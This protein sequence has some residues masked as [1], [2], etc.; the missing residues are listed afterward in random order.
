MG[1]THEVQPP[2]LPA[3]LP[4]AHSPAHT[5]RP[6]GDQRHGPHTFAQSPLFV[7]AVKLPTHLSFT[8]RNI[9]PPIGVGG[10]GGGTSAMSAPASHTRYGFSSPQATEQVR[11]RFVP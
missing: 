2:P 3:L 11:M 9:V 6:P 1:T 10:G 7:P 5:R 8:Q 4:A